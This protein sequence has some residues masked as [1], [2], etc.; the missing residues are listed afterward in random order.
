MPSQDWS[1]HRGFV[2]PLW[3]LIPHCLSQ[4]CA[5]KARLILL[6]PLWPSQPWY[7]VVLDVLEDIPQLLPIQED[8]ILLHLRAGASDAPEMPKPGCMAY[9]RVAFSSQGVSPEVSKLLLSPWRPKT[10]S[11]NNSAFAKWLAG[12]SNGTEITLLAL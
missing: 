3:C 9:L 1:H 10:Q 7:P 6:T 12:V 8:L 5:Q 2:N 4:A 11:S